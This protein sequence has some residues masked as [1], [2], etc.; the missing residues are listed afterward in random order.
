MPQVNCSCVRNFRPMIP[1]R[2]TIRVLL[3]IGFST[4]TRKA[5]A[6]LTSIV[7]SPTL[8][9]S[10]SIN[11]AVAMTTRSKRAWGS[12]AWVSMHEPLVMIDRQA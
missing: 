7:V 4:K 11:W 6:S 10:A 12:T 8:A 9:M 3:W 5:L 2:L 1:V